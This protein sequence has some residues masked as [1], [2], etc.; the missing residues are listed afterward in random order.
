[1]FLY[2][3]FHSKQHC[4]QFVSGRKP[5]LK[6]G[7]YIQERFHS[8]IFNKPKRGRSHP[9]KDTRN[10]F[11]YLRN[12]A[13]GKRRSNDT[14][15]LPIMKIS[16]IIEKLQGIGMYKLAPVVRLVQILKYFF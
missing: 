9:F 8:G 12:P 6:S 14:G 16:V 1:M 5:V 15:N 7:K 11:D 2:D 3:S 4:R 10:T 13:I